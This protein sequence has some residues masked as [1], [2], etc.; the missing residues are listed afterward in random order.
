[1]DQLTHA[2]FYA[3]R[4]HGPQMYGVI[5]YTHHLEATERLLREFG[6]I[7][8]GPLPTLGQSVTNRFSGESGIVDSIM[9]TDVDRPAYHARDEFGVP[10]GYWT[11]DR[12]VRSWSDPATPDEMYVGAWLHDVIE[13]TDAKRRDVEE[14]F[15]ERVAKLV[16]SVTSVEGPNRKT[17]NALTYPIIRE[18]GPFSVRLK[19]ADRLSH[20]RNGGASVD[21][22]RREQPDF[23]RSLHTPGENEDMWQ[24]LDFAFQRAS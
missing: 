18:A 20:I 17:R 12:V 7:P 14:M 24:A 4:Q 10:L 23:R 22:Y 15:G 6:P 16:A 19:L 11:A 21:M 1:M 3:T 9:G 2:K 5:P 13:D 8:T